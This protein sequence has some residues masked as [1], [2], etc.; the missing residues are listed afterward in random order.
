MS[1]RAVLLAYGALATATF[2]LY[3]WDKLQ[4][5]RAGRRVPE[6]QLHVLALLGGFPGS[7]LGMRLFRHKTRKL[8]FRA[9]LAAAVLLHAA[10]WSWWLLR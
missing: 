7:L 4:A 9:V 5:Q 6:A 2:L 8:A 1:F 10:G 3:G